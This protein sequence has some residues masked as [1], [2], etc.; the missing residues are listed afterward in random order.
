MSTEFYLGLLLAIPL[1]I[2]TIFATPWV[3]SLFDKSSLSIQERRLFLLQKRYKL[4][5]SYAK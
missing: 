3:K 1:G 4:V 5:G 2:L